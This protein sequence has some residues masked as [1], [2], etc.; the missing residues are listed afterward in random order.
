MA[1]GSHIIYVELIVYDLLGQR[2]RTLVDEWL[3]AGPHRVAWDGRDG[4]G[5]SVATGV[6][7][8]KLRSGSESHAARMVL[9]R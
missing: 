6:Y 3:E 8:Y 4:A 5:T 9:L 7:M 1:P 2:V